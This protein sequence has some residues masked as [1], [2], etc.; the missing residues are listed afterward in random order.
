M[1]SKAQAAAKENLKVVDR[2]LKFHSKNVAKVKAPGAGT[3][4][5]QS[6]VMGATVIVY[7]TWE[8]YVEDLVVEAVG[9]LKGMPVGKLPED[10]KDLLLTGNVKAWGLA[11]AGWRKVWVERVT[12]EAKGAGGGKPPF[13]LNTASSERVTGL[14]EFVGIDP[15][16]GVQWL[17]TP[18]PTVKARLDKLVTDRAHVAHTATKPT[19]LNLPKVTEY[20]K[21]VDNL[22]ESMDVQV[23]EVVKG[24]VGSSW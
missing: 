14:F 10:V 20:R 18:T 8:A 16:G 17:H 4:A 15:F 9:Y 7:A 24:K 6:L 23:G 13:G 12:R 19:G 1:S 11:D 22:V 21:F 5:D 2:I 3:V